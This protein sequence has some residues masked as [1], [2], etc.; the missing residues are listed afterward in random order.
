[1]E[2]HVGKHILLKKVTATYP[3]IFEVEILLKS[4]SGE[5]FKYKDKESGKVY[6][7]KVA[8]YEVVDTIT[9]PDYD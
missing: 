3:T 6:W 1:M 9:Y 4:D 2:K 8:D 7:V 5:F